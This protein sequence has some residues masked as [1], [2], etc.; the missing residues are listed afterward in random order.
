MNA[1]LVG[2]TVRGHAADPSR[3]TPY[4]YYVPAAHV[5]AVEAAGGVPV[6]LPHRLEVA[7]T[8]IRRLDGIVLSGGADVAP[9]TYDQLP[10]PATYGV[11]DERDAFETTL[12]RQALAEDIPLLAICRGIQ[13]LNVALGGTLWQH[14]PDHNDGQVA[15]APATP[16]LPPPIHTI[17]V[18]PDSRLA[19]ALG[20]DTAQVNSFHHQAI[21]EAGAGVSVVAWAAD[22]IIEGVELPA[23]RFTVGVQWH[24]ERLFHQDYTHFALFCALIQACK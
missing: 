11:D 1:P 15:H 23:N 16:A 24:P 19:R 3:R 18:T 8:L 12:V 2:I 9:A 14:I 17:R 6:L 10:H 4:G 13:V 21:R 22:G 20:R 7:P 5:Q